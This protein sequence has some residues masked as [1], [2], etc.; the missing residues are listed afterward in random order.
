MIDNTEWEWF[1]PKD[2][3][4][5][6]GVTRRTIQVWIREKKLPAVKLMGRWRINRT[7]IERLYQPKARTRR[8]MYQAMILDESP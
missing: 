8:A 6:I 2:A 4:A 3:A 5:A 1:T 7:D